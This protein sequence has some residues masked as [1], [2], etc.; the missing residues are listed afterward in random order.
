MSSTRDNPGEESIAAL[1]DEVL[2]PMGN[3]MRANA[4]QP[5]P[6]EPDLSLGSYYVLRAKRAMTHDDFTAPSCVDVA[7]LE[8][9][10]AA[11]WKA[12]GRD[13][14]AA[15]AQRFAAAAS[16]SYALTDQSAEVSPFVYVMF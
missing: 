10:L 11:H 1:F 7:D 2:E 14:L 8:I 3:A 16:A 13:D 15:V 12:L 9:R 6:L 4:A 5:F